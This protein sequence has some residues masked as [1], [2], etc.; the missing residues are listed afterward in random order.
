MNRSRPHPRYMSHP[1]QRAR[2]Q[3]RGVGL[4]GV[5]SLMMTLFFMVL[6]L[7]SGRLWLE[8]RDLQKAADVAALESSRFTG[9]GSSEDD[10]RQAAVRAVAANR[11][12]FSSAP[13]GMTF[14]RGLFSR[15]A[16]FLPVFTPILGKS[17]TTTSTYVKL[18]RTVPASI[19]SGG[20][21]G[22]TVMI[23]A[24]AVAEGSPPIAT[25]TENSMFGISSEGAD[26]IGKIFAGLLGKSQLNL[27]VGALQSLSKSTINLLALQTAAGVKS[28]EALMAIE[29]TP[30]QWLQWIA[31]AGTLTPDAKDALQNLVSASASGGQI[32]FK[33]AEILSLQLPASDGIAQV[34]I[35]V[36]D[37]VNATLII[38]NT[39]S[40]QP[41]LINIGFGIPGLASFKMGFLSP[42]KI[43][44]GPA[45]RSSVSG[46]WCT[47]AE[48][49]QVSMVAELNPL[50]IGLVDM[51]LRF[52]MGKTAANLKNMSISAGKNTGTFNVQSEAFEVA[53]TK[54]K[55]PNS[56]ASVAWGLVTVGMRFG[57]FASAGGETSFDIASRDS[58]PAPVKSKNQLSS[59]IAGLISDD[60]KIT[61]KFVGVGLDFYSALVKPILK[62]L[63]NII[64]NQVIGPVLAAIGF[65]IA[66]TKVELLDIKSPVLVLR[67]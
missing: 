56:D 54:T 26:L 59:S 32:K 13:I 39:K 3:Q 17:D 36:L 7:D 12:S 60:S 21:F 18:D 37:L 49:A 52:N 64:G 1:L 62:P 15:D 53:L 29:A 25:F 16:Q 10:A 61:V 6:A 47:K 20:L 24:E 65:D 33:L 66:F 67:K 2:Q 5:V 9:C 8:K 58:L 19:V 40:P 22:G 45:G 63:L 11:S 46:D 30:A 23:K 27:T 48:S 51:A 44:V 28:L 41:Q 57:F 4:I 42:P 55:D 14:N 34:G 35:N 50:G 31:S 43:A 38:G